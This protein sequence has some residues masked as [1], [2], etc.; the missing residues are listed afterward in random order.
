MKTT[1]YGEVKQNEEFDKD[2]FCKWICEE[3]KEIDDFQAFCE[4]IK[5][6][7]SFSVACKL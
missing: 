4:I 5:V 6:L 2:E 1:E 7:D 3:R